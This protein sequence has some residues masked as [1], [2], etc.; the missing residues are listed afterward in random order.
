SGPTT[1][2]SGGNVT[3]TANATGAISY[4][5][6]L[7]GNPIGAATGTTY[8]ATASGNYSVTVTYANACSASSAT[9]AVT[10]KPLPATPS[11]TASGPT[12][13]CNGGS[14]TLTAPAGYSYVWS[15]SATSQSI[16]VTTS[17][18]YTVT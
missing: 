12:T 10:V 2:C 5:W 15:T 1:F 17:G 6:S 7:N 14:V 4:Q 13:F 3:L 16:T 9:T 18:N 11:I 8:S